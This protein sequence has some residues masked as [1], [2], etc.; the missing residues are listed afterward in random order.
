[1]LALSVDHNGWVYFQGGDQIWLTTHRVAPRPA[2]SWRRP[3]SAT[4]GRTLLTPM[5]WVTGPTFVQVLPPLDR[6]SR[7][8]SSGRSPC[9]AS[10]GSRRGSAAGCSATGPPL[11]WVVD[12][13]R[14]DPAVRGPLPGA[15]GRAL[16]PAGARSDRYGRLPVH[17]ARCSRR[18]SSWCARSSPGHPTDAVL[19]GLL[20]RCRGRSQAARTS[21]SSAGVGLA[22]VVAR[23]WREGARLRCSPSC[24][25][26]SSSLAWKYRGLGELPAFALEQARVAAGSSVPLASISTLDRYFDLDFEHWRRRWISCASSSGAPGLPSGRRSPASSRCS[27][28]AAAR[29]PHCSAAGS[30]RFS[31][32]RASRRVRASRRT[33]SG[34]CCMPRVAR[35][36]SPVRLD[37]AARPDARAPRSAIACGRVETA[38]TARSAGSSSPRS[39][40]VALP[41]ARSPHR[42]RS[43]PPTTRGSRRARTARAATSS[44]RSTSRSCSTVEARG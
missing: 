17:G 23:R 16:P 12:A 3:S 11:L 30:R 35:L 31:S 20:R 22:Y 19:A 37:P 10:T 38:A 33:P 1:M 27:A 15:L 21:S 18:R 24:R 42:R 2:S 28:F 41:A 5:T 4:S 8:S 34:G 13:V 39:F 9:S 44:R 25:R 6:C 29:S 43:T 40:C 7:C 36:S 32:S 14:L 26:C